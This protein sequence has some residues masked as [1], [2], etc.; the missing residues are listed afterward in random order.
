M[1]LPESDT[2]LPVPEE[3]KL[4]LRHLETY[5]YSCIEGYRTDDELCAVCQADGSFSLEVAPN[6]TGKN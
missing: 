3:K 5:S 2:T 1:G 6:C 4:G